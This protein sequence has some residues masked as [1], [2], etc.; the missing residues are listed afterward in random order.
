MTETY[1]TLDAMKP[2]WA[3]DLKE[4]S[5]PC[6]CCHPKDAME[7]EEGYTIWS[8]YSK[9]TYSIL[10][11][12]S[13][14]T[15]SKP[16]LIT[17]PNSSWADILD[18]DDED[19]F[20]ALSQTEQQRI[21]KEKKEQNEKVLE[22]MKVFEEAMKESAAAENY[23]RE[24]MLK[25]KGKKVFRPCKNLY[26]NKTPGTLSEC[27][28]WEYK[29]P[30]TGIVR[31]P[32]SCSHLHPNEKGW[33]KEWVNDRSFVPAAGAAAAAP[34]LWNRASLST[35]PANSVAAAAPAAAAKNKSK[36]VWSVL[37]ED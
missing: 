13:S 37:E 26:F 28:S 17:P 25:S 6:K 8:C 7:S 1:A 12:P 21:L 2:F 14:N 33:C 32:H 36:N 22:E 9:N 30:K 20:L 4:K 15:S 16:G 11:E 3:W 23:A 19:R 35:V 34:N 31:K 18:K 24:T 29:D 27:W 5:W 10:I